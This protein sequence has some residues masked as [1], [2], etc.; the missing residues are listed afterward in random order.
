MVIVNETIYNKIV[1][2]LSAYQGLSIECEDEVVNCFPELPR[3]TIRS[4]IS[5]HGQN[6]LKQLFYKYASRSSAILA[7]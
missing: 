3:D 4:I 7:E 1:E 5:K 2:L 6:S